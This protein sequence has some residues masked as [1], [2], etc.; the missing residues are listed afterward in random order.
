MPASHHAVADHVERRAGF[1]H[2]DDRLAGR[3]RL[4]PCESSELSQMM[5]WHLAEEGDAFEERLGSESGLVRGNP[6]C[7]VRTKRRTDRPMLAIGWCC[8]WHLG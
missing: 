6:V 2:A 1:A 8:I 3:E 4:A 5:Q 7:R